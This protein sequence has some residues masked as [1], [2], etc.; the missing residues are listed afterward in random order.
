MR[1]RSRGLL[2]GTKNTT[3]TAVTRGG[4]SR[5]LDGMKVG[6]KRVGFAF[7][8]SDAFAD[9]MN[10]GALGKACSCS[11]STGRMSLG[12]L[13]LLGLRTGMGYDSDSLRLLFGS[14]GLLGLLTFVKD[15]DGDATLGAIDSLT[16]GCSKV[17]LKFRLS[18][19]RGEIIWCC[20]TL[21]G[22]RFG[23][24]TLPLSLMVAGGGRG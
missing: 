4:L 20:F 22:M 2:V 16:S 9:A 8:T 3:T 10:G 7:G 11:T 17:V 19:W 18:G 5:R 1:F 12:F 13:G 21:R 24:G 6:T 23:R 14:S 15:G